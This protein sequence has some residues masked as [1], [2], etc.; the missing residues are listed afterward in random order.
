MVDP[1]LYNI[2]YLSSVSKL[3]LCPA[4]VLFVEEEK[5]MDI[6]SL[7]CKCPL[8]DSWWHIRLKRAIVALG[9]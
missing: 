4:R 8:I 1:T 5:A 3:M 2:F 7:Y 6:P 9:C